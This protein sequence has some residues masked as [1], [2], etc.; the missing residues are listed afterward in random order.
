MIQK[1]FINIT[2]AA[3]VFKEIEQLSNFFR[4]SATIFYFVF[5]S[6]NSIQDG[7]EGWGEKTPSTSFS[8]VTSTNIGTSP[9]KFLLLVLTLLP[10]W[11]EI[12]GLYLVPVPNYSTWTKT[13][14]QKKGFFWLNCYTIEVIITCHRNA[15]VT[16]LWSHDYIYSIIWITW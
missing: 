6:V 12:S 11:C 5:F 7:G 14:S 8:P 4:L 1:R 16:K 3:S 15:R 10:H 2:V 9:P 13:T